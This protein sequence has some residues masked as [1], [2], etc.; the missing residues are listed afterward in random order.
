MQETPDLLNIHLNNGAGKTIPREG[1]LLDPET[2]VSCCDFHVTL[3]Y[4]FH[5]ELCGKNVGMLP[6]SLE[7]IWLQLLPHFYQGELL[8]HQ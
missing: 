7:V 5:C 3:E 6:K 8:E 2:L 1:S 4:L